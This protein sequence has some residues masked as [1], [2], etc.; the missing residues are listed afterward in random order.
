MK[1]RTRLVVEIVVLVV[2][3]ALFAVVYRLRY[4]GC[5][6]EKKTY[7]YHVPSQQEIDE[8]R[9]RQESGRVAAVAFNE[10]VEKL[11][12]AYESGDLNGFF[13]ITNGVP[14]MWRAS[15]GGS[16][17]FG[18]LVKSYVAA[19]NQW[20]KWMQFTCENSSEKEF[21]AFLEFHLSVGNYICETA[22]ATGSYGK[23]VAYEEGCWYQ[24]LKYLKSKCEMNGLPR[25]AEVVSK[26]FKSVVDHIESENG[27]TRRYVMS[28]AKW[29]PSGDLMRIALRPLI[30]V[31][32]KPKWFG[33][34]EDVVDWDEAVKREKDD[35]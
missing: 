30:D 31:G 26:H 13:A 5:V 12:L 20:D 7:P 35:R 23:F 29:K 9:K 1:T 2:A 28:F 14:E 27:F 34:I 4:Y 19:L 15:I 21:D 8:M 32:Y 33:E 18:K 22:L 11:V 3:A 16:E 10:K 25:Q 17:V 6:F 24:K